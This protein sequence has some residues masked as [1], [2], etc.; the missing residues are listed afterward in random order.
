[1]MFQPIY[2]LKKNCVCGFEALAR[3]H[4]EGLG[5]VPPYEFIAIAE[6][7]K[8]IIPLGNVIFT[9]AFSF[10]RKIRELGYTDLFVSV[11]VSVNQLLKSGFSANLIEL[12]NAARFRPNT[13]TLRL[14][15]LSLYQTTMR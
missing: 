11:N 5:L 14:R 2:D 10:L 13:L 3:L 12:I 4:C 7:N 6:K 15:S 9:Q 1:M 8:L